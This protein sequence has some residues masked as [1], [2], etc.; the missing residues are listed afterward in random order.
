MAKLR[1]LVLVTAA[2]VVSTATVQAADDMRLAAAIAR[3]H[4][5]HHAKYWRAPISGGL[6]AG[7]R[8]ATPLTVPFFAH[9]W[10]PGPAYYYG[11]RRHFCCAA[12]EHVISVNY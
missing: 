6:V 2:V 5:H 3:H 7:I 9:G 1:T 11:W 8:G 10:Y 12:A 4:H